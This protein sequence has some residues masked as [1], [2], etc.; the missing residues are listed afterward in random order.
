[1]ATSYSFTIYLNHLTGHF[2][3]LKFILRS[4][5]DLWKQS[6]VLL[7]TH[8]TLGRTGLLHRCTLL[9]RSESP[10]CLWLDLWLEVTAGQIGLGREGSRRQMSS[11]HFLAPMDPLL[12]SSLVVSERESENIAPQDVVPGRAKG[13][14]R[15]ESGSAGGNGTFWHRA[16]WI[17]GQKNFKP[18]PRKG[19]QRQIRQLF[20]KWPFGIIVCWRIL[21][22]LLFVINFIIFV[23]LLNKQYAEIDQR[24]YSKK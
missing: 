15:E 18:A 10:Q 24:A 9:V 19:K 6:G 11:S 5:Y 23:H 14:K 13:P 8:H 22:I 20:L 1:M 7:Q 12:A 16:I 21:Q 3:K 2:W 4:S 17:Y